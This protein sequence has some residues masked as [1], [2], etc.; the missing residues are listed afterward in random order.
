MEI[1]HRYMS[2]IVLW[3]DGGN[4]FV[5]RMFK[6]GKNVQTK[7]PANYKD[8]EVDDLAELY[9]I[10]DALYDD[11]DVIVLE[12][13]VEALKEI[14]KWEA[15]CGVDDIYY[16]EAVEDPPWIQR[17]IH[18]EI[19]TRKLEGKVLDLYNKIASRSTMKRVKI[20]EI[21]KH[22]EISGSANNAGGNRRIV[23]P[24]TKKAEDVLKMLAKGELD[25]DLDSLLEED[26]FEDVYEAA[27]AISLR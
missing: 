20:M 1:I 26:N 8:S 13:D 6:S 25:D 5:N 18:T 4:L 16:W 15:F 2:T 9:E 21:S 7:I 14:S 19:N 3:L 22:K 11:E 23:V 27:M 24:K 17:G 10:Y 12:F